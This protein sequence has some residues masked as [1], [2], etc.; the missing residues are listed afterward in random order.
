[1]IKKILLGVLIVYTMTMADT[2]KSRYTYNTVE[3]FDDVDTQKT[4]VGEYIFTQGMREIVEYRNGRIIRHPT[5]LTG[6]GIH[7]AKHDNCSYEEGNYKIYICGEN[8]LYLVFSNRSMHYY[9]S[10]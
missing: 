7:F 3:V 9:N 1:M 8:D 10:K 4:Y 2:I 6:S 5:I